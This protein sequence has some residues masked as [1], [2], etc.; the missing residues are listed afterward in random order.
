MNP[1]IIAEY[2]IAYL[3]MATRLKYRPA[4]PGD[5]FGHVCLTDDE[6]ENPELLSQEARA[7]AEQFMKHDN[8]RVFPIGCSNYRTN[9]ALVYVIE[10]ARQ[11]CATSDELAIKLLQ[12]A[13]IEIGRAT[14]Q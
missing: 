4:A 11:L 12:L 14:P 6:L 13:I 1:R 3:T 7:Y 5:G 2:A 10:A 8:D 9:R